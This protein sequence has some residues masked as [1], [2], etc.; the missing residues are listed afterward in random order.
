MEA[1]KVGADYLFFVDDDNPIPP[2]TLEKFVEDDKDIII[3]PILGRNPNG[4]GVHPLCAFYKKEEQGVYLYENITKFKEEGYLHKID[5]AGTGAMLIKRKVLEELNKKYQDRMFE[6]GEIMFDKEIEVDG[7]KYDRRTMS[8][9]CE[10]SE[11]AVNE[12]FEIWLDE[13]IKPLHITTYNM[14]QYK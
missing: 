7:I 12:G 9:D 3:S 6:F 13:R 5:A 8:E 2:D 10:F 4:E 11:R 1:L 14:I